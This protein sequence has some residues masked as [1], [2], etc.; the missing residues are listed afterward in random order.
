MDTWLIVLLIVFGV[1]LLLFI[2][3]SIV[4][5][6]MFGKN[7][8]KVQLHTYEEG[9]AECDKFPQFK[10]V[11]DYERCEYMI[12]LRDGYE[13]H[14][15]IW[16]AKEE[17]NK[18]LINLHGLG[19]NQAYQGKYIQMY[20]NLGYNI[21]TYD[22]R[23]QGKNK[24]HII[25]MG[26]I[27]SLDFLDIVKDTYLRFG[28]DIYLGAQG[29]SMGGG[30]LTYSLR[31]NPDIKFACLDCPYSSVQ[32]QVESVLKK[33]HIPLWLG[34]IGNFISSIYYGV[35]FY[36]VRPVDEIN[37]YKGPL[38]IFDGDKDNLVPPEESKIIY[39]AYESYK[40]LHYYDCV[41]HAYSLI[42]H[43]EEYTEDMRKFLEKAEELNNHIN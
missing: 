17:T 20:R 23:G 7:L 22:E 11:L 8:A 24:K 39:D 26:K 12:T 2:T 9:I 10:E 43:K 3:L 35:N 16:K 5:I 13:V 40:E 38:G 6:I 32:N 33:W 42:E 34:K 15:T 27:E 18:Y 28:K 29:E 19:V 36:K 37:N 41:N 21:I 31:Y 4:M 14:A 1:I 30:T 25:T